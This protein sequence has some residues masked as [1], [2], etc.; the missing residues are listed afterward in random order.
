ML[1][2]FCISLFILMNVFDVCVYAC[3]CTCSGVAPFWI[4]FVCGTMCECSHSF[5]L[6]WTFLRACFPLFSRRKIGKGKEKSSNPSNA[7]HAAWAM[8]NSWI[9]N[10]VESDV[11]RLMCGAQVRHICTWKHATT[12]FYITLCREGQIV[13]NCQLTIKLCQAFH[14]IK[15]QRVHQ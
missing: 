8:V 13:S 4:L 5:D 10:K 1:F 6:L 12:N 11:N 7:I 14:R 2:S 15:R 3:V 9:E